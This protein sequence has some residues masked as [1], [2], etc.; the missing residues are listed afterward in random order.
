MKISMASLAPILPVLLVGLALGL[1]LS[2][3]SRRA[4]PR[5]PAADNP[6]R[7]AETRAP[8]AFLANQGQWDH[9]AEFVAS[10][11]PTTAFLETGAWTTVAVTER[12][13]EGG[14][15]G[16]AIRTGFVGADPVVPTG[17]DRLVATHSSF[18]GGD[19]AR[20][21]STTCASAVRAG[22]P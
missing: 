20:W 9:P 15:S 22:G 5:D 4:Q 3:R 21:R 16:A 14:A 6:T 8:V 11:G 12:S 2:E 7:A 13:G 18:V 17:E 10:F 1:P 19:S